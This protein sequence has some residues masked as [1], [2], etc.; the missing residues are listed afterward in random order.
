[1]FAC[2]A[3]LTASSLSGFFHSDLFILFVAQEIV[4]SLLY[5][6][7]LALYGVSM[8]YK[9]KAGDRDRDRALGGADARSAAIASTSISVS[10]SASATG[11]ALS[12]LQRLLVRITFTLGFT[13]VATL[14]RL[15]MCCLQI[16]SAKSDFSLSNVSS[17][18]S[19]L[20]QVAVILIRSYLNSYCCYGFLVIYCGLYVKLYLHSPPVHST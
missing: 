10:V 9:L 4:Q 11:S 7:G 12:V 17:V 1:M 15:V 5:T 19:R 8:I 3:C 6:A 18:T 13:S 14:L 16:A 2:V 20:I